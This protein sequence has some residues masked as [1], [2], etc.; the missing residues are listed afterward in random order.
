MTTT[1]KPTPQH[2]YQHS[3]GPN[4]DIRQSVD[5][6]ARWSELIDAGVVRMTPNSR[7]AKKFASIGPAIKLA[8]ELSAAYGGGGDPAQA[9]CIT[10]GVYV[11]YC[12][13]GGW[14]AE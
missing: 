10:T 14:V 2:V 12:H 9:G 13:C 3:G 6:A 11:V 8:A 1:W 4:L 5:V 7:E